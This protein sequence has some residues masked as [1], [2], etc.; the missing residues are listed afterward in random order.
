MRDE[1]EAMVRKSRESGDQMEER[2]SA[3][4]LVSDVEELKLL[5]D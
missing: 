2:S 5:K 3:G 1:D 4:G